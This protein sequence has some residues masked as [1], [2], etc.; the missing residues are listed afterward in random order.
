[1]E[2][3]SIAA[4]WR[5]YFG[6]VD[7]LV[8]EV[9]AVVFI[10]LL[11]NYLVRVLIHH[12]EKQFAKT[13]NLWDDSILDAASRPASYLIWVLGLSAAAE[14]VEAKAEDA[15]VFQAVGPAR[16]VLCITIVAWFLVRLVKAGEKRLQSEEYVRKPMDESTAAALGRLLRAAIIITA[17]MIALQTL[18]YSI[19]SI[20][21][22]GGIGGIAV[23]FAA[24]DLLANFFGGMMIYL[25]KPFRVGDWVRSPDREIEG[26]VEDIGWRI[27]TIRTFDKRPLYVPNAAFT[28]MT[29]ENPSRMSNRRIYETIGLRY[30]DSAVVEPIVN[31]VKAMLTNHPDIDA[32]QTLIVNFNSYG[33]SSL[34]FFVYTFTKT[35]NWIE[36]HR[37]KQ[38]VLL[39]ILDIIDRHGA[40]IAYPTSTVKISDPVHIE[41][42][43]ARTPL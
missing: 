42:N 2:I 1:M 34:D 11:V 27:T 40:D 14:L 35:T 28:T 7:P 36:F 16:D 17:I 41:E 26:V 12:L 10:T 38:D 6:L 22:F 18:G 9:F 5:E 31:D 8:L 4:R 29:V 30:D 21:A 13:R 20:V 33:P 39:K 25:D 23:G 37:I 24:R 3:N 15:V 32:N 19:S 43:Q